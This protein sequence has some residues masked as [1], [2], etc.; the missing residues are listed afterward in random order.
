MLLQKLVAGNWLAWLMLGIGLLLTAF[1]TSQVKSRLEREQAAAT[2]QR[3]GLELDP[4]LIRER[5]NRVYELV[6]LAASGLA[7]ALAAFA[8]EA[9]T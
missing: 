6:K 2:Y 3:R 5:N 7:D 1:S 9:K 4:N 8:A